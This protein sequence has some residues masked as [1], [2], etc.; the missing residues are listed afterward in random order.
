MKLRIALLGAAA[1]LCGTANAGSLDGFTGL[2]TGTYSYANPKQADMDT[3]GFGG[4]LGYAIP[5]SNVA[6]QGGFDYTDL[7]AKEA[8][9]I[10]WSG[11]GAIAWRTADYALAVFGSYA[12]LNGGPSANNGYGSYGALGEWYPTSD[13]TLR[14]RGGGVTSDFEDQDGDG[15]FIGGGAS[16][17]V[18]P[19]LALNLDATYSTISVLHTTNVSL[20][21]EYMPMPE[22][23]VSLA[24]SYEY[25]DYNVMPSAVISNGLMLLRQG[26]HYLTASRE[27]PF[28]RKDHLGVFAIRRN[29][30]DSQVMVGNNLQKLLIVEHPDSRISR[31]KT[32]CNFSGFV[33]TTVIDDGVVP[34]LVGLRD[35]A[36]NT[37]CNVIFIVVDRSNYAD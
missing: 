17:Y 15:G 35:H 6:V 32:A 1:L 22:Y 20:G 29:L 33:G 14:V 21:A 26:T 5:S 8:A 28:I 34:I 30:T 7:S 4:V 12:N 2:L 27:D 36:F 9:T 11:N 18:L 23:P 31:G 13:I 25:N 16:Y 19:Q 24:L 10:T 37:F 3:Y